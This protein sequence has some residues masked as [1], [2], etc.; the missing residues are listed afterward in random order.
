VGR[1]RHAKSYRLGILTDRDSSP[2]R[3]KTSKSPPAVL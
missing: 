2:G 1:P 3:L